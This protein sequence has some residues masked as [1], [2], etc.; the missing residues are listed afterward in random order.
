MNRN[1]SRS[2]QE[3]RRDNNQ[4]SGGRRDQERGR[5]FETQGRGGDQGGRRRNRDNRSAFFQGHGL[6]RGPFSGVGPKGYQRTDDRIREEVNDYLAQHGH[7]DARNVE[8]N[9][10]NGEV[11]LTGE[12]DNREMKLLS[13]RIVSRVSGVRDVINNIRIVT[14]GEEIDL[15]REQ[16][17]GQ[18]QTR[19]RGGFTAT[20]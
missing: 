11:T 8:V 19:S 6:P 10:K 18:G 14:R 20:T 2:G 12:M 7:I 17:P 13:E 3:G 15:T 9:V 16:S 1:G 4:Q 5:S